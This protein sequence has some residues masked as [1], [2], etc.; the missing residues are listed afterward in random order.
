MCQWTGPDTAS[1]GSGSPSADGKRDSNSGP[2]GFEKLYQKS[3]MRDDQ[4]FR[5]GQKGQADV[6]CMASTTSI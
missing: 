4:L 2:L 5:Q 6:G 1:A 3:Q